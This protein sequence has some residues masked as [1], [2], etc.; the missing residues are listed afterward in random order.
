MIV[1]FLIV[2]AFCELLCNFLLTDATKSMI[3]FLCICTLWISRILELL[4]AVNDLFNLLYSI[5]YIL[6]SI[7]MFQ[8]NGMVVSLIF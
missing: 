5:Y 8:H 7:V 1:Q 6:N 3:L 4:P 2:E